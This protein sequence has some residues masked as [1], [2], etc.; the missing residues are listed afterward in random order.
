L[1]EIPLDE[2][3]AEVSPETASLRRV[4]S[5]KTLDALLSESIDQV[6]ADVLGRKAR[7]AI[8]DYIERNYSI[9][10]E[11]LPKNVETFLTVTQDLFGR[12][13]ETIARCLVKRVWERLGWNFKNIPGF[14]FSDYI[15]AAR[16]RIAR[17]LV[18]NSRSAIHKE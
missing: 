10:R 18:Q 11:D 8:Y 14:E 9:A 12:G 13:S 17:E 6:L 15:E 7:E 1:E 3:Q 4:V 16:A 5:P 2:T